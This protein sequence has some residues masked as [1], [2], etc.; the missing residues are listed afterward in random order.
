M[1]LALQDE[2]LYFEWIANKHIFSEVG[3]TKATASKALNKGLIGS[4]PLQTSH[5]V[6]MSLK[7]QD[8]KICHSNF[9]LPPYVP[10]WSLQKHVL[11][12]ILTYLHI[13]SRMA[14]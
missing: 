3:V 2:R 8:L 12:I 1:T 6:N 11:S 10:L 4:M 13:Y 5:F 7:K 14:G 9:F